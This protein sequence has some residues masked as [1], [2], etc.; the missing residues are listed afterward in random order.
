MALE[1]QPGN[2]TAVIRRQPRRIV[3]EKCTS[4]GLC[5]PYCPL[6]V[7]ADYNEGL[8]RRS[9]AFINFPQAIPSTYSIDREIPPCVNR[10]PININ[11]R[12][13][14]GLISQGRFLE[15]LDVIREKLPFPGTIGRIC[16]HPCEDACLRGEEVD[17]P[18]SIC[19]LKRFVADYETGRREMPVPEAGQDL[20]KKV[21]VIGGGPSGMACAIALRKAGY[22]VTIFEAREKLGGMLYWGIP[23]YRLPKDVLDRETSIVGLMGIEVRYET[24]VG[25][26]ISLK[27][28]RESFDAVYAGCGAQG[29]R[30]IGLEGE[31]TPGVMSGVEFLRL[32]NQQTP[33]DVHGKV[34]VV[35]GGNVAVDVALTARR[36]G[37]A[38]VH[39]ICLEKWD[40]MPASKWEIEQSLE[41]GI[42]IH[43]S[44]GPCGIIREDGRVKAVEFRRCT[45]VFDDLGRF[46]PTFQDGVRKTYDADMV[47]L[48]IG[49]SPETEFLKELPGV[50]MLG[51]GWIK[52]DPISLAT[53]LPGVFAGGDI[54]TGPKMAIDAVSQGQEAAESIIRYL[55]GRDLKE[56]RCAKEAE[57]VVEVPEGIE[58]RARAV[59]PSI[60]VDGRRGFDEVELAFDEAT[61]RLEAE[62]C[63]NCRRCLGCKICEE[64]CKPGAINYL[65]G[66][67]EVRVD[68]GSVIVAAGL[69]EYDPSMR[70][71]LGY[72]VYRNV[73][74]STEFERIL[75]ATGPTSSMVMRPSDGKVPKKVAWLQCVGSRDKTNEY[76]S[77]VCCMYATKEA[78]I[79]KEH[80]HDIEPTIFYMDVRAFGKGFDQYYERAKHE[81]GVRYVKSSISRILEDPGSTDLELVYI[82][83][84]GR[85][86]SE[87]FDMAVLSVGIRPSRS[88]PGLARALGIGLDGYGF[89]Q[90]S[91]FNPVVTTR[92]GIYVAGASEAPKDIPETVTQASGAACEAASVIYEVRGKDFVVKPLPEEREVPVLEQPRIGVFICHC[93]VNIGSV[94]NV[95][96]VREYAKSLPNVVVAD[97]NLFTCSQDTQE[98]MKHFVNEYSLNRVV[99]ASCS[100]RTHEFLFRSTIREA[101]LNKYLF[102]MANIRDQCSWVHMRDK[103][104]AT[105]KAKTLVKMA[106]TNANY[107]KPL[108]EVAIGVNKSALVFGGGLAGMTAALKLAGQNFEVFLVEKEAELGGN[109]RHI[110]STL[111]GTDVREFLANLTEQV[112]SHPLI[113]VM[114]ETAVVDHSGF[115]GNFETGVLHGPTMGGAKA[116]ARD[117]GGGYGRRGIKAQGPVPL[118]RGRAGHDPDGA[119]G[120]AG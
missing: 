14:V 95:P 119:G 22:G 103:E 44:W 13:Y 91:P 74:T 82:D 7:P 39:M 4:C 113:H 23:A 25:K 27:D 15:A 67:E 30:K 18:L 115:Q 117:R 85:V 68:V 46:N 99:V 107:I 86:A 120:A 24:R 43:T 45:A 69:E 60:P 21:A 106:V 62:R 16:N 10:C 65:Q 71:E 34:V 94:V 66:P 109:L 8:S 47:I 90:S 53:G 105:K 1:G 116:E 111:D 41:E 55:E 58:R 79:A 37:D 40:E 6:E 98:K 17:Q 89:V 81:H 108:K 49:Q 50:E 93:G 9:A 114:T 59:V 57:L 32:S 70:P 2:F 12:D 35:G 96:E 83:E 102:E 19:A 110:R 104:G 78:I 80:Q 73:V 31:E 72:G 75:S 26:D 52:A 3:K 64:A 76:C 77:S 48:A 97:D 42:K 92:P 61:A 118:R 87:M 100:P 33:L 29:G 5:A 54:V 11:A 28:I 20:G 112:V 56:G 63:L 101:G 36:L 84:E 38:E 88:L 51:G